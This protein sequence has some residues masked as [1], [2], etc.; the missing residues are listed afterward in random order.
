MTTSQHNEGKQMTD[1]TKIEKPFA[2]CSSE[3][4]AG[5]KAL[6]NTPLALQHLG[7]DGKWDRLLCWDRDLTMHLTYRQ[8]PDWQPPQLDVPDWFWENTDFNYVAMANDQSVRA[9]K[10]EPCKTKFGYWVQ[11]ES[12]TRLDKMFTHHNF[13][14][15]NIPWDQS[16]TKRPEEFT[17]DS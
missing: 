10:D 4:Q 7:P 16:L 6:L 5:L 2:F 15:H 11:Q 13:N 3:E 8:N 14:P 17:N 1:L 12:M 9:Y